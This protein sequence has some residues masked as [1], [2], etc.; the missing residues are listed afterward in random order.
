MLQLAFGGCVESLPCYACKRFLVSFDMFQLHLGQAVPRLVRAAAATWDNSGQPP[1][2]HC[3]YLFM[4][5]TNR[6]K[7][8]PRS[9]IQRNLQQYRTV[10]RQPQIR[11]DQLDSFRDLKEWET[12]SETQTNLYLH[13]TFTHDH[14]G[15]V[16]SR[17][18]S[19]FSVKY[20]SGKQSFD[21]FLNFKM[22][23]IGS[24]RFQRLVTSMRR[25]VT[26]PYVEVIR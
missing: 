17:R 6:T 21:F 18:C 5:K 12:G 22:K 13:S 8:E 4:G 19:E 26:S 1:D 20:L 9:E 10:A 3:S 16:C 7:R 14:G 11:T 24:T 2:N 23:N 15:R 25:Y